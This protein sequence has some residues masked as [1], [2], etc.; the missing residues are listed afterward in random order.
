MASE[1]NVVKRSMPSI[2]QLKRKHAPCFCSAGFQPAFLYPPFA[3]SLFPCF[4]A[5][6]LLEFQDAS[7][8]RMIN[9]N[10]GFLISPGT[11]AA[12]LRAFST[13]SQTGPD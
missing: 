2:F 4:F 9:S 8:N 12:T 6:R 5:S 7:G 1:C 3:I 10:C 11:N 13:P